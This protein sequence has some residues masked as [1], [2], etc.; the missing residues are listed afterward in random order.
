MRTRALSGDHRSHEDL[1]QEEEPADLREA[2]ADSEIAVD[3]LRRFGLVAPLAFWSAVA[4]RALLGRGER[5]AAERLLDEL[6]A[7]Q[8]RVAGCPGAVLLSTRGE[9]RAATGR[10]A[11]ARNDFLA[12]AERISWLPFANPEV[13]PWRIGLARCEAALGNEAEAQRMAAKAVELA[14]EAGGARGI[15]I[16]LREQGVV[17]GG[18]KGIELLGEAV[19]ILADTRARLQ[20]AEALLEHGAALRRANFRKEAREPLREALELAHRCGAAPLEERARAELAATGAR[21]RKAVLTGVESLTP[22]ELRVARMAAE[23]MTNR[24]IAQSL[25]VTAKTVETHMRH[26]FQKLDVERRTELTEHL[27]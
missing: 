22:S 11:E 15:G 18:A 16:T 6:W 1:T 24:E 23:G 20:C 17:T 12:A 4:M 8:E 3:L 9:L 13:V 26:V 25:T 27:G 14:R 19:E 21:P 10:H 7:G 5:I 2:Q